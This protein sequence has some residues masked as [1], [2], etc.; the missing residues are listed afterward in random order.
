L[1]VGSEVAIGIVGGGLFPR[2][3]LVLRKLLP[4]ARL[5]VIDANGQHLAIA[6]QFLPG[7][8][9]CRHEMFDGYAAP[10]DVLVLPLSFNGSRSAIYERP[11]A[12]T[13]LVH[14]WL[15]RK[16]GRSAIVSLALLKRINLIQRTPR[17]PNR[18]AAQT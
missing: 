17:R 18:D 1:L 15:W 8:V 16:R 5:T 6:R 2:T 9:E 14:D 3:A 7:D 12:P 13:V 11:A 4:H 10:Y